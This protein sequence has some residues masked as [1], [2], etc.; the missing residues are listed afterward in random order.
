MT[1]STDNVSSSTVSPAYVVFRDPAMRWQEGKPVFAA[2][3]AILIGIENVEFFKH[4]R[5]LVDH[6]EPLLAREIC[7]VSTTG[8]SPAMKVRLKG[9]VNASRSMASCAGNGEYRDCNSLEQQV[10]WAVRRLSELAEMLRAELRSSDL[11]QELRKAALQRHL[12]LL[13]ECWAVIREV[14]L[15]ETGSLFYTVPHPLSPLINLLRHHAEIH[16]EALKDCKHHQQGTDALAAVFEFLLSGDPAERDVG[17]ELIPQNVQQVQ[18]FVD[19]AAASVGAPEGMLN[20]EEQAFFKRAAEDA[21]EH[22]RSM[23][24]K[25]AE[26]QARL[27]A[28]P[29]GRAGARTVAS[30]QATPPHSQ[31]TAD[32]ATREA[33]SCAKTAAQKDQVAGAA[34]VNA[35]AD[36]P[37]AEEWRK[38]CSRLSLDDNGGRVMLDGVVHDFEGKTTQQFMLLALLSKRL[39]H[40][41]TL[42]TLEGAEG[43]WSSGNCTI[44]ALGSCATKVRQ[45]LRGKGMC[46]LASALR[47]RTFKNDPQARLV[48]PPASGTV[49]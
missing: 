49:G 32:P 44:D 36:P 10:G 5:E 23:K 46:Q 35:P 17:G 14:A 3:G 21:A 31:P 27:D 6:E 1:Q 11:A 19:L 4:L 26:F 8:I 47:T 33:T 48:W 25:N 45:A 22:A 24:K 37:A 2:H 15:S 34:A 18:T 29:Y 43:P 28:L 7:V 16:L 38:V 40:W 30:P 42:E 39:R 13:A 20:D 12:R 41:H 9:E